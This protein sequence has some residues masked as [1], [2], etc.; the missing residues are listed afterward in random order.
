MKPNLELWHPMQF[1][2]YQKDFPLFWIGIRNKSFDSGYS[3]M[4]LYVI[5]MGCGIGLSFPV[6]I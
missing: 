4:G 3:Y 1:L 5:V 2:Q 6:K